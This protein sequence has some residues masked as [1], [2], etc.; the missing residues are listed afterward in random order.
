MINGNVPFAAFKCVVGFCFV[1]ICTKPG[2]MPL[3]FDPCVGKKGN[4]NL[5]LEKMELKK[6]MCC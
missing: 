4:M 5:N 3:T 2:T 6:K 1:V